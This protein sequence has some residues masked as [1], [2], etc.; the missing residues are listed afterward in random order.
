[1]DL[2]TDRFRE[3]YSGSFRSI[4]WVNLTGLVGLLLP[5]RIL[6][7]WRHNQGFVSSHNKNPEYW[8]RLQWSMIT[9]SDQVGGEDIQYSLRQAAKTKT[10][11]YIFDRTSHSISV[12][13]SQCPDH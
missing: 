11:A 9:E 1:M 2:H 8:A 3:I 10:G 4:E 13:L 6:G 12:W 7:R 5:A